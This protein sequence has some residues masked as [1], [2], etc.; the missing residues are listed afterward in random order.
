[1]EGFSEPLIGYCASKTPTGR[2]AATF[3][4][5]FPSRYLAGFSFHDVNFGKHWFISHKTTLA[6]KKYIANPI[7]T[8]L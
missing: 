2:Q 6:E 3:S 7:S 8:S 1:M 5:H 4:M